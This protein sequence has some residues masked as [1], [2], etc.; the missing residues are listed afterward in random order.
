MRLLAF[1]FILASTTLRGQDGQFEFGGRNAG[2]AGTSI[3]LSDPWAVFNNVGALGG[4]DGTA[5]FAGYQNRYGLTDLQSLAGGFVHTAR[6]FTSGVG[7]FRFGGSLYNQQ[8]IS[9]AV[10]NKIQFVSLGAGAHVI[11]YHI[12]S[13]ETIRKVAFEFGGKA[14]LI[15]KLILAANVFNFKQSRTVPTVMKAGLSYRP[16]SRLMLNAEI[17]KESISNEVF[18]TG[19]EYFPISA[20]AFRT[21]F[22]THTFKSYF[23]LGFKWSAFQLDY[24]FTA[25]ESLGS[26]HDVSINYQLRK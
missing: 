10:G 19:I 13:L 7:Y 21:G 8:R 12:E 23:G 14:E 2:M 9:L 25:S 11:Q 16:T 17:E 20:V 24:A 5:A 4:F 1:L 3:T 15:P 18:R 6:G 22:S 26:I